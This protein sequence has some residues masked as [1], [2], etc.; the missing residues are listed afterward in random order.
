M[1]AALSEPRAVVYS[2]PFIPPEW[3]AAHGWRPSRRRPGEAPEAEGACRFAAGFSVVAGTDVRAQIFAATCDPMRRG[4]EIGADERIPRFLFHVPA[5]WQTPAAHGYY[6]DELRR[7]GR[8]LERLGG[9]APSSGELAEQMARHEQARGMLLGRRERAASRAHAEELDQFFAGGEVPTGEP[10]APRNRAAVPVMLL[11]SPLRADDLHL[12]D[13]L[14]RAGAWVA[15]DAT[16]YGE[17]EWPRPFDRR[18]M[19]TDA[20]EELADAYFGHIPA[21]F[22]RPNSGFFEWLAAT[23]AR[24][25]VRGIVFVSHP[26]CDLW[27]AELP[28]IREACGLP[29]LSLGLGGHGPVDGAWTT[30]IQAF[31]EML[32]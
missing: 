7:L 22:R 21:V 12:F 26:W 32:T 8:F 10:A 6:R 23:L 19:K 14:D 4:A 18:A 16:E 13:L 29:V 31:L 27:K 20:F 5:T 3:I 25:P 11:G 24:V 17:R 9:Q 15:V 28:R 30:R 2:S 1:K